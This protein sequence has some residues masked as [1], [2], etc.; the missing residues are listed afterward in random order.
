MVLSFGQPERPMELLGTYQGYRLVPCRCRWSHAAFTACFPPERAAGYMAV[1]DMVT[2]G[3][4]GTRDRRLDAAHSSVRS[5][6][7][8]EDAPHRNH[9][10]IAVLGGAQ[11]TWEA[12]LNLVLVE[13][14]Y[15]P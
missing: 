12:K 13:L 3:Y 14:W 1:A 2:S 7:N 4:G 11:F 9:G 15:S 5:S 6:A 10:S 8:R